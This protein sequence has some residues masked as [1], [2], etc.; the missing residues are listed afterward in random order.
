[1]DARKESLLV[2]TLVVVMDC[3]MAARLVDVSN[4][5][6][7]GTELQVNKS[8]KERRR[9]RREYIV[10]TASCEIEIQRTRKQTNKQTQGGTMH[11]LQL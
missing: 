6:S 1:M 11:S 7:Q 3:L 5:T 4:S 8:F 9:D 2:V 10:S